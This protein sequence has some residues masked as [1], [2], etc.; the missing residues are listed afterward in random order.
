MARFAHLGKRHKL[1]IPLT[2]HNNV[3]LGKSPKRWEMPKIV[4]GCG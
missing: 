4:Y 1:A 2:L 3:W